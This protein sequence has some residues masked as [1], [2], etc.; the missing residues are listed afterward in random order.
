MV[1]AKHSAFEKE[2]CTGPCTRGIFHFYA[3]EKALEGY[4]TGKFPEGS[5]IADELLETREV[6]NVAGVSIECP[7]RG[8]GV[9]VKDSERY[10]ASGGWGYESFKGD[11]QIDGRLSPKE[12]KACFTCHLSRKDHDF[13]FTHY[14]E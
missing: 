9:M 10:A 6:P 11:S 1:G 5:V 3:N 7:R 2:P 4:R 8:V 12:A 14:Q 13:V